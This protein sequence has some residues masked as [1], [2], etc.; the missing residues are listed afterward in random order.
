MITIQVFIFMFRMSFFRPISITRQLTTLLCLQDI[1]YKETRDPVQYTKC[2]R[3]NK[4][5]YA[6]TLCNNERNSNNI[7]ASALC[8]S[9]EE[10]RRLA[11]RRYSTCTALYLSLESCIE[12]LDLNSNDR[13]DSLFLAYKR[14]LSMAQMQFTTL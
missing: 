1:L 10:K 3:V 14:V 11:I 8:S 2:W 9:F 6:P 12:T 13:P 4:L 5:T 7:S